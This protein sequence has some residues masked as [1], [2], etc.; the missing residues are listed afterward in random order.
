MQSGVSNRLGTTATTIGDR[1]VEAMM[2]QTAVM[3]LSDSSRRG[4]GRRQWPRLDRY[5]LVDGRGRTAA[6]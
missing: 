6:A 1:H 2:Q 3:R 5:V 4:G